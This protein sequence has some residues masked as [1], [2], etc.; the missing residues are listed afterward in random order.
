VRWRFAP[1]WSADATVVEDILV[2]TAADVAFQLSL[3]YRPE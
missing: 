3:R 2:E 1:A